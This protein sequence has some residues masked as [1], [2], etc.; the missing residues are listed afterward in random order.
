LDVF[1]DPLGLEKIRRREDPH[2]FIKRMGGKFNAGEAGFFSIQ[3]K[4]WIK[5]RDIVCENF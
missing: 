5:R 2:L 4:I 1:D 3:K